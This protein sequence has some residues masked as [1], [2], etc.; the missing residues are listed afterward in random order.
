MPDRLSASDVSFLYLEGRT[1]PM[2]A[3]GLAI[4]ATVPRSCIFSAPSG[5][6]TQ[7]WAVIGG[8]GSAAAARGPARERGRR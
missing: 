7:T 4:F 3:G 1:T 6:V 5:V 8:V 2:H